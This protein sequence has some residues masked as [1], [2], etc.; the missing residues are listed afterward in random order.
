MARCLCLIAVYMS[1]F[2]PFHPLTV[3]VAKGTSTL[4]GITSMD[5]TL[6][7]AEYRHLFFV[8]QDLI[9]ERHRYDRPDEDD[10][11]DDGGNDPE[12]PEPPP[13]PGCRKTFR[14]FLMSSSSFPDS[15]MIGRWNAPRT[16]WTRS[17]FPSFHT[18]A[19]WTH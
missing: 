6:L 5:A 11:N 8:Q 13:N 14:G 15:G 10:D 3:I 17:L 16:P 4:I 7:C 12:P 18:G 2:G 1:F 19:A 9:N